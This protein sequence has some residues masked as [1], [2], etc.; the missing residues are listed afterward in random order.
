VYAALAYYHANPEAI[1]ADLEQEATRAGTLL[2]DV[3]TDTTDT[4]APADEPPGAHPS[5]EGPSSTNGG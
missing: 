5:P 2:D 3:G 1:D 4:D